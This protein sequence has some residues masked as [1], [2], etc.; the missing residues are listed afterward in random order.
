M[1]KI[2]NKLK[3]KILNL[4]IFLKENGFNLHE[5]EKIYATIYL[6]DYQIFRK[7]GHSITN[8]DYIITNKEQYNVA[9]QIVSIIKNTIHLLNNHQFDSLSFINDLFTKRELD[10]MHNMSKNNHL[11]VNELFE[12]IDNK[13]QTIDVFNIIWNSN[14]ADLDNL[15]DD[16]CYAIDL[17]DLSEKEKSFILEQNFKFKNYV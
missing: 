11:N 17:S 5:E 3:N 7:T 4:L 8:I 9:Q 6:M 16:F 15:N 2:M 12:I 14:L 13:K 10:I 1:E